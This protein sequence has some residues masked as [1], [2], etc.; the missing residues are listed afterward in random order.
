LTATLGKHLVELYENRCASGHRLQEVEFGPGA[1]DID[2]F[3][4][5]IFPVRHPIDF[6]DGKAMTAGIISGKLAKR[7]LHFALA[8]E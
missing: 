7:T 3:K 4:N 2:G 5:R 6:D 1:P 8:G